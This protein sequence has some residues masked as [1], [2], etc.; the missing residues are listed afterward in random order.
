MGV[1][2]ILYN[3]YAD[4]GKCKKESETLKN[5]YEDAVMINMSRINN[6]AVFFDGLEP[7][8]DVIIC[9]GDGTLNGFVND[10]RDV[11]VKN[12]I[13][14]FAAGTENDFAHDLGH[15]GRDTPD[16]RINRYL[17]KLPAVI[18]NGEKR[19]FI[20]GVGY[21]IDGYCCEFRRRHKGQDGIRTVNYAAVMAREALFRFKPR[22]ALVTVDGQK[23][24]YQK[25]WLAPTLNGR[26]YCGGMMPA[27]NQDR[28]RPDRKLT[29]VV[30]HN[31]GKLS[32]VKM[33]PLIFRGR[34]AKHKK[35][36]SVLEGNTITVR[37]DR[38]T[39]FQIDG[40]PVSDVTS[41]TVSTKK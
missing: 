32:A 21:G 11:T 2:Y 33:F 5:A 24:E 14:Y 15:N 29:L 30:F 34:Y 23:Y 16:F 18:V 20:N 19:L 28:L 37:F 35:Q 27:P 38:P 1:K 17:K 6:Y 4:G 26:Y 39:P 31:A 10:T 13:F 36:V 41:Y 8:A 12:P 3:P 25:V 9:G 40:E 22:N 7:E